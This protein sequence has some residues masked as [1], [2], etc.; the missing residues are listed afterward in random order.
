M[1]FPVLL[2]LCYFSVGALFCCSCCFVLPAAVLFFP[3]LFCS[4]R[5]CFGC[6]S[7]GCFVCF[8]LLVVPVLCFCSC[9][10]L[11]FLCCVVVPVLCCC[12]CAILFCCFVV[13]VL[14]CSAI[15]LFLC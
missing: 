14:F 2:L 3:V 9:A 7:W 10:F 4:F 13:P 1:F 11:L 8:F 6:P 15:L 12:S 5:C